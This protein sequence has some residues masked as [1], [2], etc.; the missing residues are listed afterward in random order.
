[1][2]EPIPECPIK[3]MK[4]SL[5]REEMEMQRGDRWFNVITD[6]ILDETSTIRGVVHIMRDITERKRVENVLK[7]SEK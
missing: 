3:R 5:V 7:E 4:S 2:T 6:P 1:M